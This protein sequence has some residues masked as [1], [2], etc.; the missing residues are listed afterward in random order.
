[1]EGHKKSGSAVKEYV[2]KFALKHVRF[3]RAR[4]AAPTADD[5]VET[6]SQSSIHASSK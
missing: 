6:A 3:L 1:M 5:A 4:Y 2:Q